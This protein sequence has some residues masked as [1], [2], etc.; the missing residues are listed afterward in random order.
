MVSPQPS[1]DAYH[2]LYSFLHKVVNQ[3]ISRI[4]DALEASGLAEN[5]IIVFILDH[6][7]LLGAHDGLQQIFCNPFDEAIPTLLG[8]AGIDREE[9]AAVIQATHREVHHLPGSD[10]SG[11][12]TAV[13]SE[14]EVAWP[15]YFMSKDDASRGSHQI[16][17]F[18]G[19]PYEAV[20]QPS[21]IESVITTLPSGPS[22]A[23][24]IWKLNRYYES[25]D[26]DGGPLAPRSATVFEL[27]NLS[28]DP[29]ERA[30]HA[31]NRAEILA[32]L[33]ALPVSER[34]SQRRLPNRCQRAS[35]AD[36][37]EME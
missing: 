20:P 5:T 29:E 21:N 6:R 22:G 30:N 8:L 3:V 2:H 34:Q 13:A 32:Q 33:Q 9:T 17:L 14:A 10:L 35:V 7:E 4:L 16:N 18:S 11:L 28:T 24:E 15:I 26:T 25:P 1:D 19:K 31:D 23:E 12:L 27:H 36:L 37:L